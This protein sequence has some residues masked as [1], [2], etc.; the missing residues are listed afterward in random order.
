MSKEREIPKIIHQIWSGVNEPLPNHFKMLGETWK[1][2]HSMWKY[3]FWDNTRMNNFIHEFYPQY[4]DTF[5]S[6]T[7]NVQ[8]WDAIRYLILDK[9]G[10]MYVDFD[11]ECLKPLDDLFFENECCFSMEP[12]EHGVVFNK[13]LYFNNAL[14]ASIPEHPFMKKIVEKVFCYTPKAN[15]LSLGEKIIEILTTTGPL[16]LVD[17]YENEPNQE[18]ITLIPAKY[19]SPYTDKEIKLIMQGFESDEL[20][21]KLNEAYSIHYFFNGW[22]N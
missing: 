17:L 10:G 13:N 6:F 21:S 8:R 1:E 14:M 7:Y 4:L 15:S 2:H 18:N 3:E 11:S 5:N 16:L 12:K 19:V 20:E 22:V 9:F